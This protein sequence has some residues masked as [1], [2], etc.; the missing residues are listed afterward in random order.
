MN[1]PLANG[2]VTLSGFSAVMNPVGVEF[3][4]KTWVRRVL[5]SVF[6]NLEQPSYCIIIDRT[7]S[8]K[9]LLIDQINQLTQFIVRL[10]QNAQ[11]NKTA[12][13]YLQEN[14]DY[15]IGLLVCHFGLDF[16]P[17]PHTDLN[18][19]NINLE[20][21]LTQ[22]HSSAEQSQD[23]E[24]CERIQVVFRLS[25]GQESLKQYVLLPADNASQVIQRSLL[26]YQRYLGK[27]QHFCPVCNL[28]S[29]IHFL[30]ESLDMKSGQKSVT[31]EQVRDTIEIIIAVIMIVSDSL[32]RFEQLDHAIR[33]TVNLDW[34]GQK[35]DE[36][37]AEDA[38]DY[39]AKHARFM[40]YLHNE[41]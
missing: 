19:L 32:P 27:V 16:L 36:L 12:D 15:L 35:V 37:I 29:Q 23:K 40:A 38:F 14:T 41:N 18:G 1:E 22:V 26:T 10:Q 20:Q 39:R 3:D 17:H 6:S 30:I 13:R 8:F 11:Q 24:W 33:L 9:T 31:D 28:M 7:A 34:I 2:I 21:L 5:S 25:S 4:G